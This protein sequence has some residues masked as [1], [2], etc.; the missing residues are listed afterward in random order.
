MADRPMNRVVAPEISAFYQRRHEREGVHLL[1]NMSV[2]AFAGTDDGRVRAVACGDR[3]FPC[4]FVIV[5]VGILPES[6]LAASA[7]L[8][9]ENGITVDEHCQTSDPNIYAA[10]D[11]T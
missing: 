11:C 7:G 1:C 2:T 8:R 9:C 6:T 3:E 10:G 4:D 5:G